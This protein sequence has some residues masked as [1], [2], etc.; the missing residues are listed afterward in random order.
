VTEIMNKSL[1][2]SNDQQAQLIQLWNIISA[3]VYMTSKANGFWEE[4]IN[5]N[6][7]EMIA[8]MHSELSECLEGIRKNTMDDHIPEFSS[9]EAELADTMIRIMDYGAGFKLRVMEALL[10]KLLY[11]KSRPYKHGKAF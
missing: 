7:G 5:R 3:D 8:L 11:N 4:G 2:L 10:A 6:R 9:E 1:L